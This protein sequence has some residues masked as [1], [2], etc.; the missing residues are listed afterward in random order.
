MKQPVARPSSTASL[1]APRPARLAPRRRR[2]I[3]T[4]QLHDR[5]YR[6]FR[7]R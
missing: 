4:L 3:F 7:V 6:P 2:A 5:S 1:P